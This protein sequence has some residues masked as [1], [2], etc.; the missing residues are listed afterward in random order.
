MNKGLSEIYKNQSSS[1]WK[2]SSHALNRI[3]QR[4]LDTAAVR[5]GIASG[6]LIE[7]YPDDERGPAGLVLAGKDSTPVHVVV[8]LADS[9]T[10]QVI[11]SYRPNKDKW[12]SD[13]RTRR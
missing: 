1:S 4:S 6:E 3:E 11:T 13:Y 9:S 2:F 5:S 8:S 12:E 10:N 7:E